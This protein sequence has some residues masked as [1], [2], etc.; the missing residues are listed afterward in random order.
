MSE[1]ERDIYL[2]SFEKRRH[3]FSLLKRSTI[4][5]EYYYVHANAIKVDLTFNYSR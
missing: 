4:I 2:A 1:L 3:I 5:K